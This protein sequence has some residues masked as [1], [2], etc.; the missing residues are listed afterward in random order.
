[1]G[2]GNGLTSPE[3]WDCWLPVR[4]RE[5]ARFSA[6]RMNENSIGCAAVSP[7]STASGRSRLGLREQSGEMAGPDLGELD[8]LVPSRLR[9]GRKRHGLSAGNLG[10][11]SVESSGLDRDW[12]RGLRG[13]RPQ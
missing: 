4:L 5:L 1:M 3:D 10:Y 13:Y 2:A 7:P 8:R 12:L 9:A 11:G 6:V